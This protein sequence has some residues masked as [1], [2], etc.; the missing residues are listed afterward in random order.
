VQP[1]RHRALGTERPGLPRLGR[2]SIA[3][4]YGDVVLDI[5]DAGCGPGGRRGELPVVSRV[6]RAGDPRLPANGIDV[7]QLRIEEP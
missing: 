4:T 5:R 6:N 7:D 3:S 2:F 1:D